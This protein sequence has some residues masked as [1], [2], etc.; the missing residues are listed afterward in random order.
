MEL[1]NALGSR[2]G[3]ELPATL[4]FDYPTVATLAAYLATL[5]TAAA[6]AANSQDT[7]SSAPSQP[8]RSRAQ[9]AAEIGSLV[10]SLLG[11]SVPDD[12]VRLG[13][14][15]MPAHAQALVR[16]ARAVN[17]RSSCLQSRKL[18]DGVLLCCSR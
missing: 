17:L 6:A 10:A 7:T 5:S 15:A 2:L 14:G 16:S 4:T 8:Q 12:Q 18:A 13:S 1:R 3:A 11:A 9:V